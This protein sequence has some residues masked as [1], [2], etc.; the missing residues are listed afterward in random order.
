M[1]DFRKFFFTTAQDLSDEKL[2]ID[3]IIIK[4]KSQDVCSKKLPTNFAKSIANI[5]A[6]ESESTTVC[7]Q[8]ILKK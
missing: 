7:H 1:K 8:C 2:T 4:M 3:D 5:L 6:N